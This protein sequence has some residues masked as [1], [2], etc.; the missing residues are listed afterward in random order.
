MKTTKAFTMLEALISLIL[1]GIIIA[2]TYSLYTLINKQ[3]TVFEKENT[4]I[5]NYHLFNTTFLSDINSSNAFNF[6]DDAL[7]LNRYLKS[8]VI[9]NFN[10]GSI[11]RRVEGMNIDT[12]KINMLKKTAS[13]DEVLQSPHLD[14]VFKLLNDTIKAHYYLKQPPNTLINKQLFHEDWCKP[15]WEL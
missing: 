1:T 6:N 7:V 14:V 5:I 13:T 10:S 9:Y 12:F 15:L 2:L 8:D 4:E 11:T 3:M